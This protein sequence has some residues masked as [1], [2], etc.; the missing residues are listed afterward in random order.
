MARALP[1]DTRRGEILDAAF[2]VF[3]EHG[4][5]ALST[6]DLAKHLGATTGVLYHWFDSKEALFEAMLAR[7]VARQVGEA[8]AALAAVPLEGRMAALGRHLAIHADDLQRTLLV[9][10]DYQRAHPGAPPLAQ[11]LG[12]YRAALAGEVG[13]T[14]DTARVVVSLVLGELLQRILDPSRSLEP[15]ARLL[16]A[17]GRPAAAG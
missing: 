9:S 4:Y 13:L 5:H 1:A 16:P 15:L 17:L 8:L 7:Q 11:A 6:R 2:G 14:D 12:A 3:A 10:L